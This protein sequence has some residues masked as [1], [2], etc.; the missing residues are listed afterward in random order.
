MTDIRTERPA[1]TRRRRLL[2]ATVA[3][4][5]LGTLLAAQSTAVQ[6][7]LKIEITGVGA[8]QLPV[9]VAPFAGESGA[10]SV[11]EVIRADLARTGVFK[12]IDPGNPNLNELSGIG[13]GE[14]KGRG[15][16]AL[17]V[18]STQKL[19]DGRY[20]VRFRLHDIAKQTPIAGFSTLAGAQGLRQAGH[21]IA[22]EIY[23]KLTGDKGV[24]A[25]RIA[26][27]VRAGGQYMLQIADSDGQSPQTALASKEPLISPSW[28]PDGN[29]LAYVSFES[30][31]P[32]IY[33]HNL[34]TGARQAVANFKGSNSAPAWSPDGRRLAVVLTRDGNSQIYAVSADGGWQA[35]LT[36]SASIDTEPTF[37][38]DGATI[39]FTSDRGGSPQIYRMPATGGEP[40]RVTFGVPYAISPKI[41]PDGKLLTYIARREG[42]FQVMVRDLATG[43]EM[44]VTDS[45]RDES[46]SFAPNG[47]MILYAT[48]AGGRGV[49]AAV[50]IDGRIKY[51]LTG[52]AGDVRE[53]A[54]GPFVR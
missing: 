47:K 6:A 5:A 1:S 20:D 19:A 34:A 11:S 45:S 21:R 22:D 31:K 13:Y 27:V 38:P 10:V 43:Q 26:Y 3:A 41:S 4:G 16:D 24:F 23:E 51:R 37:S 52:A 28:A 46:P 18:G 14:W 12:V 54:W 33:V 49:L 2:G 35:R 32:V 36:N 53:P 50:S 9:A 25:T 42:R 30:R 44:A 15:V 39:Y 29:R 48:D 7:Q 17:A 8:S 40:A